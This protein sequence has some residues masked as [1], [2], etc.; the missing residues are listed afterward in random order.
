MFVSLVLLLPHQR[1]PDENYLCIKVLLPLEA[2]QSPFWLKDLR[3]LKAKMLLQSLND[4]MVILNAVVS[5]IDLI[6]FIVQ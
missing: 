3:I 2:T 5:D 1:K 6:V 4:K